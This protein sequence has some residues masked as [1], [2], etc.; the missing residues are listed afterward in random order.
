MSETM[1]VLAVISQKGGSGK[2]TLAINLAVAAAE[3]GL[4]AVVIDM[5]PQA[6]AANWKDRRKSENPA[7]VSAPPSRLRQ[8]LQA[9][10]EHGADFV[11]IDN[12]GKQDSGAI[13]AASVADLVYVPA[14]PNMFHLE[15]LPGVYTLLQAAENTPP[16]FLILNKIHPSATTQADK[17][18]TMIG[19][20]YPFTV[21]PHHLSQLD[22]YATSADSGLS[23]LEVDPKG[24]PSLEI[25]Q[26]YKF[27]CA[28]SD[29]LGGMLEQ[30]SKFADRA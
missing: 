12:P 5:D 23:V 24:R 11:V 14:E 20:V 22:A 27:T 6:N 10:A 8:T 9:A 13:A 25:T 18:K 26:I 17:T 30:V 19:D 7:V 3:Q 2:T 21:C 1:F 28:Q 16:A 15:T 4:A 29:K